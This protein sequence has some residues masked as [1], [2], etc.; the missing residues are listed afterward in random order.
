MKLNTAKKLVELAEDHGYDM[1][2][3]ENYSGRG[4][5]GRETAGITMPCFGDFASFLFNAAHDL[6]RMQQEGEIEEELG[7]LSQDSMGLDVIV[8]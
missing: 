8:Y 5:Y 6:A 4:M 2:L 3:H 7:S 1:E